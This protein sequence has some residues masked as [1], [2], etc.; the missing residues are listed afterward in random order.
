MKSES[1]SDL[2]GEMKDLFTMK[3]IYKNEKEK[4][5]FTEN[6]EKALLLFNKFSLF[7]GFLEVNSSR[8]S[9]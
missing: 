4:L 8:S 2:F 5:R 7:G 6:Y 1:K 9:G 3:F